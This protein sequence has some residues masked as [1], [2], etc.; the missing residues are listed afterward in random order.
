MTALT[1]GNN[2]TQQI[3]QSN[4]IVAIIER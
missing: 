2:T 4:T 1:F 3:G